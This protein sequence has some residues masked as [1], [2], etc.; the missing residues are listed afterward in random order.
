MQTGSVRLHHWTSIQVN[1]MT[2][3]TAD[4]SQWPWHGRTVAHL[5]AYALTLAV[6]GL[7]A[8]GFVLVVDIVKS[9]ALT[10]ARGG[11]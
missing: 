7:C 10:F 4:N 8:W 11:P 5:I 3:T 9:A 1:D 6:A 2:D